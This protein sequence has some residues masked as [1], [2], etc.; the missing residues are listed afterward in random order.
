MIVGVPSESRGAERRVA[1]VPAVVPAIAKAGL[2]VLVE[3][4]AGAAAGYP[5]ADYEQRGARLAANRSEVLGADVVVGIHRPSSV[6]LERLRAG[7]IVIGLLDPLGDPDGVRDLARRGVTAFALE[8]L[9]RISRAQSMDALTSMATVA[10]YKAALVTAAAIDKMFPLLMTA[11]GTIVPARVLVLGAGV[12][13]LQAIATAHR[14]GAVVE[15][16]DIRPAVREQIE[17]LG[18][19]FVDLGLETA[20]AEGAG[21]YARAMDEAFYQRQ[22]EALAK[23]VAGQDAVIAT[24]AVPGARAPLLVTADAVR[25]MRH[26]AV[27][28]DLAAASGGNCELTRPDE[29]VDVHGVQVIGPTDLAATVPHDASQMYAK[30]IVAFLANLVRK[31]ELR[32]D[33]EDQVIHD[34]MLAHEGEVVAPRVR[35]RLGLPVASERSPG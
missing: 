18:A 24:A 5:D 16:Y 8:L 9:P 15:A 2:E 27:I 13:G 23:V 26:G 1:L 21:G 30:N 25:G 33:L 6:D 12:A 19:R 35:E 3:P 20:D 10:G 32:L 4:G 31:G 14:L 28:V 29:T 11:A 22:R 34:S 7:Q 17:S